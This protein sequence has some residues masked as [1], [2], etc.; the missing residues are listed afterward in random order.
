MTNT[1]K[2]NWLRGMRE[3]AE[4]L[5]VSEKT[6]HTWIRKENLPVHQVGPRLLYANSKQLDKFIQGN[7]PRE[8]EGGRS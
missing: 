1:Q 7:L 2:S 6:V 5:M 3:I 4:Y 8:L